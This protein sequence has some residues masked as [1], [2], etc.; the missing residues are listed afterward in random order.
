LS[1]RSES[2]RVRPRSLRERSESKRGLLVV[3]EL[4]L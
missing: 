4:G 3:L 2:K 1:E